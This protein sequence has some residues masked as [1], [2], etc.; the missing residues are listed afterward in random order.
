MNLKIIT[1]VL[2]IIVLSCLAA[3]E[4]KVV[5][6]FYKDMPPSHKVLDKVKPVLE[7]Y[8]DKYTINYYLITDPKNA[9]I[10]A[11]FGLPETHFPFAVVIGDIFTAR[12]HE[13]VIS[14]VH[15]PA[16]MEGIGR[17]EGNW[18]IGDLDV[19]LTDNSL[20]TEENFL[21]ELEEETT[22]G[23]CEE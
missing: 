12:L 1:V 16:F 14:F 20:L 22:E 8:K 6:V 5:S 19:V 3:D 2:I 7:W 13:E 17:H 23:G 4:K 9:E 18:S 21:P 11:E 10:I 15:F